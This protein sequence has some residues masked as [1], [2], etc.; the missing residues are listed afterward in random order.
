M[1]TVEEISLVII[2]GLA[3]CLLFSAGN[4]LYS[5]IKKVYTMGLQPFYGK[6]PHPLL[7]AG[8]RAAHGKIT[9][10]AAPI[11]RQQMILIQL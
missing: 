2:E 5:R 6:G 9:V 3:I 1:T 8:S 10:S 11:S 7:W 4:C